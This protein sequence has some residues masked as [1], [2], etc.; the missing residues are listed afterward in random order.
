MEKRKV[1]DIYECDGRKFILTKFDPMIGNYILYKLLTFTLPF[2]LSSK[3]ATMFGMDSLGSGE[4]IGKEEF[5][6]L[7]KDVLS[8]VYERLPDRDA[9]I[10]NKNG[11]YGVSDF[12]MSLSFVL[13]IAELGF[14]FASF[15]EE[16]GLQDIIGGLQQD[17]PHVNTQQ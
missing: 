15:F 9:P 4:N 12:T 8:C 7:Q 5:I 1:E 3:I 14:N 2:G 11:S 13:I 10:L 6:E 17:I 16:S